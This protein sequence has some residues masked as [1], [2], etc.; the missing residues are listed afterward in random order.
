[1]IRTVDG[2]VARPDG[3]VLLQIVSV[4]TGLTVPT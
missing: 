2:D 1:M 3:T 4:L